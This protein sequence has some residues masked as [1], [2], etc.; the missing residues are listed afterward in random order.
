MRS[1]NDERV[2]ARQ[3]RPAG[4]RLGQAKGRVVSDEAGYVQALRA[5]AA[6]IDESVRISPNNA[7]A[8]DDAKKFEYAQRDDIELNSGLRIFILDGEQVFHCSKNQI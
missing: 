4:P 8:H 5:L 1:G 3:R 6:E 7:E 2:R